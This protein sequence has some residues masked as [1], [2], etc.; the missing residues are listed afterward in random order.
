LKRAA[1]LLSLVALA[2][3]G[4]HTVAAGW[5]APE[6]ADYRAVLD[7]KTRHGAHPSLAIEF[8][9][10]N[11]SGYAVT[12]SIKADAWR[13]KRV[14][15]AGF[16]KADQ[17]PGGGALW[18][19]IDFANA[20]YVLDGGLDLT[21]ADRGS[22][23][24]NGWTRTSLVA[25]VPQEALGISFGLRMRGKGRILAADLRFEAVPATT[26]TTTIER[27]GYKNQPARDAAI[28]Q[29]RKQ[30]ATAPTAPVNLNFEQP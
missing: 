4:T 13:G 25:A 3:N 28:E 10:A 18:M 5:V 23:D 22:R 19:R 29:L 8:T 27:R 16:V 12:E 26:P 15:L 30:F 2:Q 24:A 21:A 17:A 11:P 9:G 14:R 7:R 6:S 20:D 1:F